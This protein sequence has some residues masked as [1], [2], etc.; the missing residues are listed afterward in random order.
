[1]HLQQQVQDSTAHV[2]Q[3]SKDTWQWQPQFAALDGPAP[4]KLAEVAR[5]QSAADASA[6]HCAGRCDRICGLE[7]SPD[8][9]LLAAAGVSKQVTAPS[10]STLRVLAILLTGNDLYPT[11]LACSSA[12]LP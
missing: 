8:G 10:C 1:M 2:L 7:F 4:A 9:Q 3:S 11:F 6:G 12:R 5:L